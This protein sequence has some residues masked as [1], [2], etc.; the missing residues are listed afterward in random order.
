M[1][2]ILISMLAGV[3]VV[4]SRVLNTRLSEKI[5]LI[6]SSYLII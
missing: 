6:E 3:I 1:F 4:V 5:G 2:Y